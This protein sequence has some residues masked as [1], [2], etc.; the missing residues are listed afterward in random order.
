M[1]ETQKI[2]QQCTNIPPK[3]HIKVQ[4]IHQSSPLSYYPSFTDVAPN[5]SRP[6]IIAATVHHVTSPLFLQYIYWERIL[7]YPMFK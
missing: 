6:Q 4:A 7:D 3:F 5:S 1:E 2:K